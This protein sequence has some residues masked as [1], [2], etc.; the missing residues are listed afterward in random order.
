MIVMMLSSSPFLPPSQL[1]QY[2]PYERSSHAS[3]DADVE[4]VTQ[5]SDHCLDLQSQLPRWCCHHHEYG[6]G[7]DMIIEMMM[8]SVNE[9]DDD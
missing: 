3:M 2:V 4:E 8:V 9:Y 1:L 6:D 5:S 7:D